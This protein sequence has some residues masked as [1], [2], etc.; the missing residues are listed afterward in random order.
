[1]RYLWVDGGN[2][3]AWHLLAENG[4]DGE[5]YP[6]N[7]P[8]EDV[9]RRLEA[10]RARGHKGGI[11]VG[12]NWP[13]VP[14]TGAGFAEW[15][16]ELVRNV[17]QLLPFKST[18]YPKVQFNHEEHEPDKILAMIRRW[19]ELRKTKDTS[20][21]PEGMQGG[22][23]SSTFVQGVVAAKVRVV[24]Q[25]YNGSMTLAYDSLAVAR[26]LTARGYPDA[27]ISPFY[28]AAKLPTYWNGFAFTQ[29]RIPR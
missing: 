25:C 2:D 21:S 9:A 3:A 8:I 20:W 10:S 29:G 13:G 5:F 27:L 15:T 7:D 18:A 6:G 26:N 12:W 28:D 19:R 23:M 11:Y 14:T 16:Y 1:V 22:W 4:V 17:E 24:P